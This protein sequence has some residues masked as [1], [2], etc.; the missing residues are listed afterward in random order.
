[1]KQF[2]TRTKFKKSHLPKGSFLNLKEQK[3]FF[4]AYGNFA[5]K[6]LDSARLTFKQIE[7]GRKSI[8][9]SVRKAG[10]L[11]IRVFTYASLTKKPNARMG[12]GKGAHN[13]WVCPIKAGQIVYE[14]AGIPA[15][16]SK[17]ALAKA[18]DKLP[19]R[20]SVVN[21]IY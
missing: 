10:F 4:P 21:L 16:K 20:T 15:N 8:R 14:L 5:L 13:I 17:M 2:P 19:V 11:S 7:A 9:R 1:M 3:V 6:S 18:G 12:K